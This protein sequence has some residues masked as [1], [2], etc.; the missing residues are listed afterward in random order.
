MKNSNSKFRFS[1]LMA[2]S[3]LVSTAI[4]AQKF[5]IGARLMPS[6]S[7]F[8]IKNASG[9]TVKGSVKM[10]FGAGVMVG[11][12]ISDN[13]G[14]EADM[15]YNTMAQKY[16]HGNIN[17]KI[18]LSYVSIPVLLSLNTNKSKKVNFNMVLGPQ[19]GIN[20]GSKITTSG[21]NDGSNNAQAI[22]AL[23]KNDLGVAY[24][25]GVDIGLNAANTFRLGFGYRGATGLIDVSDRSNSTVTNTYYVL[26]RTHIKT[27]SAY[28]GISFL[29]L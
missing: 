2:V 12:N 7:S 11:F 16:S 9:G 14:I 22:L 3:L 26:D 6:F 27:N 20:V 19:L 24:G 17:Q 5:E 1:L 8:D 29:F 18:T 4:N 21:T 13:V 25:A 10:G 28:V 23:K 15:I